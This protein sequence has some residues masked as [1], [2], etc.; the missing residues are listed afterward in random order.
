MLP[1]LTTA[2]LVWGTT[3]GCFLTAHPH[4]TGERARVIYVSGDRTNGYAVFWRPRRGGS[5]QNSTLVTLDFCG[6]YERANAYG[7]DRALS[8]QTGAGVLLHAPSPAAV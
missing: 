4:S 7:C 1:G 2:V 3:V 6:G 8:A 5:S